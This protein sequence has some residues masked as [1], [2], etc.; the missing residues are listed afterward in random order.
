M[1]KYE[2]GLSVWGI[3]GEKVG[4]EG[5]GRTRD[6]FYWARLLVGLTLHVL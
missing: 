2:V 3:I 1:T 6:A 4:L 5:A